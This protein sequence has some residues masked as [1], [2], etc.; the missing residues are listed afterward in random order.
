[1]EEGVGGCLKSLWVPP[2]GRQMGWDRAPTR[3]SSW[4]TFIKRL[5]EFAHLEHNSTKNSVKRSGWGD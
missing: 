3:I 1:M 2:D 4:P 5:E